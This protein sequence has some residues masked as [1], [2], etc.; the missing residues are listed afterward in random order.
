MALTVLSQFTLIFV[1][2]VCSVG[3]LG[4]SLG[5][6]FV[7]LR[8]KKLEGHAFGKVCFGKLMPLLTPSKISLC[9]IYPRIA[10]S[11]PVIQT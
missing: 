3:I 10:Q 1:P 11:V 7:V 2:G 8:F 4:F 9:W 5:I 6:L